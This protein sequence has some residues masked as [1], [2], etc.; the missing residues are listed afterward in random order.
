M[1]K[2]VNQGSLFRSR[3][4]KEFDKKT[5]IFHTSVNEDLRI[6]EDDIN[7][8]TAHDIM[9]HEQGII[10]SKE[11]K[12][13]LTAIEEI[14][15]KWRKGEIII[16]PEFE[17]VHEYIETTII[18]QIGIEAGGMIHTGR[19]RNDQVVTDIKLRLREDILNISEAA[20]NL[21]DALQNRG[22]ENADTV[23][24]VYT[25][26]QHGQI[27]TMGAYFSAYVDILL[28]DQQRLMELYARVNTNPLGSGPV[29]GTSININRKRTTE[30]L[31]FDTIQENSIDATSSRDWAMETA[32]VCAIIMGDLS[33]IA[34]DIL[35]WSTVE[36]GYIELADEYTSSSSIMPQKKNP[37]TIELLR[38]KTGEA[39]GALM[40]LLTMEK[41]LPTGYV[42]DLQETKLTLWRTVENTQICLEIL[43]GAITTMKIKPEKLY[44]QVPGNFAMA[45]E[46]A[47]TLSNETS[48]SFR[49]SYKI[50]ADLVNL[51]LSR[52]KTL[53][54]LKP[55]DVEASAIKLF[56]KKVKV[57]RALIDKATDPVH[58]L[59]R[60]VSLGSPSPTEVKRML[61]EHGEG[62]KKQ[63]AELSKKKERIESALSKL[64]QT[65]E[66]YSS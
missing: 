54:K 63:R 6:F 9:L 12:L 10:P 19:S 34:A 29:G 11:L 32:A 24:I 3:L 20:L 41:G 40:E 15:Q 46:L 16:G 14:R 35:E 13:I 44:R 17:D 7:C 2:S 48:L 28:R 22:R 62:A 60:R 51:S 26:G 27:G 52:G 50:A 25:H 36:F 21:V 42:Q 31:G 65:S 55:E 43:T 49:E 37:S 57:T 45:V 18:K 64:R 61:K 58:S 56:K 8:T 5:A 1:P 59:I 53:D 23:M 30:L 4:S 33:R 47:E 38:G 66:T 39:Y